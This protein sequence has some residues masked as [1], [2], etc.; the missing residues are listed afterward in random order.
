MP[1][2]SRLRVAA[3]YALWTLGATL[4]ALAAVD[5]FAYDFVQVDLLTYERRLH[6]TRYSYA[7]G[8]GFDHLPGRLALVLGGVAL[9]TAVAACLLARIPRLS[10][11]LWLLASTATATIIAAAAYTS[12]ALRGTAGVEVQPGAD[13]RWLTHRDLDWDAV[14]AQFFTMDLLGVLL[15]VVTL[16]GVIVARRRQAWRGV[17]AVGVPATLAAC[18]LDRLWT[19]HGTFPAVGHETWTA[20]VQTARLA[21]IAA[22]MLL[23]AMGLLLRPR[24]APGLAPGLGLLALGVAALVATAPHRAAIDTLYPLHDPGAQPLHRFSKRPVAP[25]TLD[26][27]RAST[28]LGTQHSFDR[29]IIRLDDAGQP[30]LVYEGDAPVPLAGDAA[31]WSLRAHFERYEPYGGRHVALG[32]DRRV[33]LDLLAP[34]LTGLPAVSSFTVAGVF[35]QPA[36][37]ADGPAIL[38]SLCAIG[39]LR[40]QAF[41]A[42]PFTPG[43]TW[44]DIVADPNF[45]AP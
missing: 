32:I 4:I 2:P 42:G 12:G 43:A 44:G 18:A 33:P 37:T 23:A 35:A 6:P 9:V 31:L 30:E 25:W 34:L 10:R 22:C 13:L 45:V 38:W 28:C 41:T 14:S 21:L 11:R 15:P 29:A 16:A 5:Y 3:V 7:H 27:P 36:A 19:T 40:R 17:I 24:A 8:R 39:E 26:L 1:A 20:D